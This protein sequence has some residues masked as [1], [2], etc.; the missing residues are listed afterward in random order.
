[1]QKCR[2]IISCLIYFP[3]KFL[4]GKWRWWLGDNQTDLTV[5]SVSLESRDIYET[6]QVSESP[7]FL[8]Y[9]AWFWVQLMSSILK[10]NE[11]HQVMLA[12]TAF[13]T[14]PRRGSKPMA[15]STGETLSSK[16]R[17]KFKVIFLPKLILDSLVFFCDVKAWAI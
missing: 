13:G 15:R 12:G 8:G 17:K 7:F 3:E 16:K 10:R 14:H 11:S 2:F 6:T 4:N 9:P 5:Y 1:M